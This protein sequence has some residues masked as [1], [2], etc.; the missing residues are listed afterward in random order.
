MPTENFL[1]L[2]TTRPINV[3]RH[4]SLRLTD[5]FSRT[6][7]AIGVLLVLIAGCG[8]IENLTL[9][10]RTMKIEDVPQSVRDAAQ[11]ALPDVEFK[12]AWKNV[13][14]KGKLHSYE[15]RGRTENGKIREAR[16]SPTGEIL[17]ME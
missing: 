4:R 10:R 8:E 6:L 1:V 13:D 11:K 9:A 17:E 14:R 5:W 2:Q 16:V 3:V 15:I 7:P 12:D